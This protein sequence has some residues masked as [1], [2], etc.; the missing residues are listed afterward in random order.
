MG[1]FDFGE[2]VTVIRHQPASRD[3]YGQLVESEPE[4]KNVKN[5]I[6]CPPDTSVLTQLD[7]NATATLY[8]PKTFTADLVGCEVEVRGRTYAV[9]GDP[10]AYKADATPGD[11]NL[12]VHV[13][14]SRSDGDAYVV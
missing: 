3:A 2:T 7:A 4:R 10:M 14:H 11:W 12:V 6:V 13:G 1:L 8:F 9:I 5:V